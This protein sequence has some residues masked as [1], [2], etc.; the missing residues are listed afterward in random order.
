MMSGMASEQNTASK[1]RSASR[2]PTASQTGR[3]AAVPPDWRNRLVV[4]GIVLTALNLRPAVT[5]L[6]V[7]L[8]QVRDDLGMSGAVAGALTSVPMICF[9]VFGV[10]APRLARRFGP[11]TVV[12]AGMAAIAAGLLIR[13]YTGS[14]AGLLAASALALMGIAVSNILLPVIVKESFPDR[15][16][17]MTGLYSMV[18][19]FGTS[20]AAAVTVPITDAMGDN[21]RSGLVIW[22]VP[23]VVA[24]LPWLPVL[25]GGKGSGGKGSGGESRQNRTNVKPA[26]AT[27]ADAAEPVAEPGVESGAESGAVESAPEPAAT[28]LTDRPSTD[29]TVTEAGTGQTAAKR[30]PTVDRGPAG[31]DARGTDAGGPDTPAPSI[32]RSPTAWA[33]TVFFGLQATAAYVAMGWIPQIFADA[34]VSHGTAGLLLGYIMLL[35]VPFGYVVPRLATRLRSQGP[36]VIVL[37]VS[38]VAGYAGLYFAP[39]GGAWLWATF[40]GIANTA[41]PLALTMVGM[42]ARTGAG[43]TRLSALAQSAGYL[44]SIPGPILVGVLYQNTGGWGAPLAMM[45]G[46]LVPQ[47]VAGVLAGR[48]RTVEDDVAGRAVTR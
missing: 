25:I 22:A 11:G 29:R 17:P 43:V 38:G 41:F 44:L 30:R 1:Q 5:S 18:M 36:L 3:V 24:V 20:L 14:T 2:R 12:C 4:V 37:G 39:A 6:G 7:L 35:G 48:D 40:L 21:W 47:M 42:R 15:V 10:M 27:G 46:L 8:E 13:P 19:A 28:P 34:G 9:A 31:R 45:I 33:L 32:T 16:G 26:G 23:A